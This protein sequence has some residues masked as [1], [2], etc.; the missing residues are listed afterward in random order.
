MTPRE[1]Q[2][3]SGPGA[4]GPPAGPPERGPRRRKTTAFTVGRL[5]V[6]GGL[7]VL[8]AIFAVAILLQATRLSLMQW[9][10]GIAILAPIGG[11]IVAILWYGRGLGRATRERE[12]ALEDLALSESKFRGVFES[13]ADGIFLIDRNGVILDANAAGETLLGRSRAELLGGRMAEFLEGESFG[14]QGTWIGGPTAN[15]EGSVV[16]EGV[17]RRPESDVRDVQLTS[18]VVRHA[19]RD[20]QLVVIVR[21]V[22]DQKGLQ[23]R[24][25]ESERW[26]SMGR[27]ASF[28]AHEIN[29]PLTNISLLTASIARRSQDP[30]VRERLEKIRV[31]GRIA[32]NITSELLKFAKPG[33]MSPVETDLREVVKTSV[34]HAEVYRRK[35]VALRIDL[36]DRPMPCRVDPIRIQEV[37]VNLLKNAYEATEAGSVAVHFEERPDVVAV[38]VSDTGSGITPENQGRLFEPF[39]TTKK[40][41]EGTGLG[42]ALSKSFVVAHGGDIAVSSQPGKGST[43]AVLLPRTLGTA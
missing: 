42:L 32:A 30:E 6:L 27:L 23:R 24:L 4:A 19:G 26:A 38:S 7:G 9:L 15:A 20:P 11:A 3:R 14:P 34:E 28:V 5:A 18:Q 13:A 35:G 22:T 39:F 21:D 12:R 36:G 41:G 40:M 37:F 10:L 17:V 29:T 8:F 33:T 43:F 16:Y 2:V 31:Q 1:P 25:L